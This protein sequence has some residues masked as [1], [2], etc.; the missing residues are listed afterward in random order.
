MEMMA[1]AETTSNT[2][3]NT[4]AWH[5]L[6]VDTALAKLETNPQRGLEEAEAAQR[7]VHYG[8]N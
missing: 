1:E 4:Q 5:A 2:R 8:R 6:D 3:Q 7:L